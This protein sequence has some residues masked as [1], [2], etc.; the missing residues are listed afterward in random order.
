MSFEQQKERY[1]NDH[2]FNFA[3]TKFFLENY[4]PEIK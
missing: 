3:I 4:T 1:M 2:V